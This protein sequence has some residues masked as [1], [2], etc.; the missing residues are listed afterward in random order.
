M[1]LDPDV[2]KTQNW[3]SQLMQCIITGKQPNQLQPRN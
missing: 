1:T 3:V 2:V